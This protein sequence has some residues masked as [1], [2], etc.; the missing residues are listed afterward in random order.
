MTT[1]EAVALLGGGKRRLAEQ[2][3][4]TVQAIHQWGD[5]VPELRVYQIKAIADAF[6]RKAR[7]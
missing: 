5:T 4:I 6:E 7:A 1:D 2:L 3:G